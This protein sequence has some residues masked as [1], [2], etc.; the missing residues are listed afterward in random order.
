LTSKLARFV[1]A[2]C[3]VLA[4]G[5]AGLTPQKSEAET[6]DLC[7]TPLKTVHI[8]PWFRRREENSTVWGVAKSGSDA[9]MAKGSKDSMMPCKLKWWM[10]EMD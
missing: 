7:D 8:A 3:H 9:V 1:A 5:E 2:Y 6:F 4:R 10:D